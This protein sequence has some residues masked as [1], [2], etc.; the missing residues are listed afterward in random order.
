MV[1]VSTFADPLLGH[2]FGKSV[3]VVWRR[4]KGEN[5]VE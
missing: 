4:R 3:L 2:S 1:P 5:V